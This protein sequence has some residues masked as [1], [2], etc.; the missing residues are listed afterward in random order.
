MRDLRRV[1]AV[2]VAASAPSAV[3]RVDDDR[4]GGSPADQF[5]GDTESGIRGERASR[6]A[7]AELHA[8]VGERRDRRTEFGRNVRGP[9]RQRHAEAFVVGSV[10]R[11]EVSTRRTCDHRLTC[12][13]CSPARSMHVRHV[14]RRGG[15]EVAGEHEVPETAVHRHRSPTGTSPAVSD[16]VEITPELTV[17]GRGRPIGS[18]SPP[19]GSAPDR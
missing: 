8:R 15:V 5:A 1:L 4:L 6:V 3:K 16:V 7:R 12:T 2:I 10:R 11:R 14:V 13:V 17:A 9:G 19:A 18:R